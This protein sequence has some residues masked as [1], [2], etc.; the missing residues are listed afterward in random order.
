[1]NK[2]E[3]EFIEEVMKGYVRGKNK[4][5]KKVEY[6]VLDMSNSNNY[7]KQHKN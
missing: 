5:S 6:V 3:I 2:I 7:D 4:K 1:M